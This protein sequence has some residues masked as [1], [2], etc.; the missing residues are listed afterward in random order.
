M[1]GYMIALSDIEG[2]S[3]ELEKPNK[4]LNP[5]IR[6]C[7][8]SLFVQKSREKTA[9]SLGGLGTLGLSQ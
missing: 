8:L 2:I 5:T 1:D 6:P 4:K 3:F 7:K 9:H